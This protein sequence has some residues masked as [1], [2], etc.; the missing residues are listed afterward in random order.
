MRIVCLDLEG[1]LVPEIW[2]E[3]SKR[4][5]IAEFSR[6]TRDEP[7]YDKLMRYRIE[8]LDVDG[9]PASEGEVSLPLAQRPLGLM[10]GYQGSDS[11]QS[12]AMREGHYHTGDIAQRDADGFLG[13]SETLN[14]L[15]QQHN[16][17]EESIL[18]P[19]TDRVLDG[20]QEA[21]IGAM[22]EA[23]IAS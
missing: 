23:G 18:Y 9:Q 3:F 17:K 1:V 20:R 19:M 15:M 8:L 13:N 22:R 14:T 21:L 2:I 16:M 4:T 6:T 7:D 12:H 11:Q 5:G 10:A